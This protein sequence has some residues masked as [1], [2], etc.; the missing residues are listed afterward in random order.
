MKNHIIIFLLL[1]ISF[2]ANAQEPE[3]VNSKRDWKKYLTQKQILDYINSSPNINQSKTKLIP[4]K[5]LNYDKVIAYD[6]EGSE[7]TLGSIMKNGNFVSVVTKQK[8][9]NQKQSDKII[10]LLTDKKTYGKR[11]AACFN[12]HMA[13]VF[14]KGSK[15]VFKVD[16]CLSCNYL[17]SSEEIP[18]MHHKKITFETGNFTYAE[19]F[20]NS[21]KRRIKA[22]AKELDFFYGN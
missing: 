22:L 17:I 21:G 18:A 10:A 3:I 6:Y 1:I 13:V 14:F 16:I 12:P 19:G 8:A 5:N 15:V 20:T 7:G 4:F 2:G 9:L 11:T